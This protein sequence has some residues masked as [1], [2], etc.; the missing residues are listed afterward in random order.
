MALY[1]FEFLSTW[2]NT[3][4]TWTLIIFAFYLLHL[5]D[6]FLLFKITTTSEQKFET[7]KTK[8]NLL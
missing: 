3:V 2:T 8:K 6:K 5:N 4:S 7:V 1:Q